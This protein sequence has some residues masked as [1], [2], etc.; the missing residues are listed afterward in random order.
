[1]DLAG[2]YEGLCD[3]NA[4]RKAQFLSG[5]GHLEVYIRR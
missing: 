3:H 1:M 4:N 5:F 2:E